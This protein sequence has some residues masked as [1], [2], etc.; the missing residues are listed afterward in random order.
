MRARGVI[1]PSAQRGMRM[2][3]QFAT[4]SLFIL[5]F[6]ATSCNRDQPPR[7]EPGPSSTTTQTATN[8]PTTQPTE[9]ATTQ[10]TSTATP[11]IT[12][13]PT[14]NPTPTAT[15]PAAENLLLMANANQRTANSYHFNLEM[16]VWMI[17]GASEKM[18]MF[19]DGDY[20]QPE[21]MRASITLEYGEIAAKWT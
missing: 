19:F 10:P 5:L 4:A 15:S 6:T 11:T 7:I 16:E 12:L 13:T 20:S 2:S 1:P 21:T 3:K 9:T 17:S 8:T 18:S 14:A